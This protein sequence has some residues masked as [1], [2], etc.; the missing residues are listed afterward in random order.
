MPY[1]EQEEKQITYIHEQ[2]EKC[3][4]GKIPPLLETEKVKLTEL[5]AV[6]GGTEKIQ[7][8]NPAKPENFVA[9]EVKKSLNQGPLREYAE[10]IIIKICAY[11]KERFQRRVGAG[12]LDDP[13]NLLLEEFKSW[14][15]HTLSAFS[16]QIDLQQQVQTRM[17]YLKMVEKSELFPAG[18]MGDLHLGSTLLEVIDVLQAA[19]ITIKATLDSA[20]AE[21][22]LNQLVCSSKHLLQHLT[23]YLYFIFREEISDDFTFANIRHPHDKDKSMRTILKTKTGQFLQSL[24]QSPPFLRLFLDEKIATLA[25][26]STG[27]LI[28]LPV[29]QT[30]EANPFLNKDLLPTED[31]LKDYGIYP[32]FLAQPHVIES[33]IELHA[34]LLEFGHFTL[35]CEDL[36]GLAKWGGDILIYG[37]ANQKVASFLQN[38]F[39]LIAAIFSRLDAIQKFSQTTYKAKKQ[40]V[41]RDDWLKNYN[42][43]ESIYGEIENDK[44]TCDHYATVILTKARQG[45]NE[46]HRKRIQDQIIHVLGEIDRFSERMDHFMPNTSLMGAQLLLIQQDKMLFIEQN[47]YTPMHQKPSIQENT[48]SIQENTMEQK[49]AKNTKE[50]K[51]KEQKREVPVQRTQSFSQ[52]RKEQF[53]G[54]N[55]KSSKHTNSVWNSSRPIDNSKNRESSKLLDDPSSSEDDFSDEK[56]DK[57]FN[58]DYQLTFKECKIPFYIES[59]ITSFDDPIYAKNIA[60]LWEDHFPQQKQMGGK[61]KRLP[62]IAENKKEN[63]SP[64]N[65]LDEFE[66]G[67]HLKTAGPLARKVTDVIEQFEKNDLDYQ[68][69]DGFIAKVCDED[70]LWEACHNEL[71]YLKYL[72][73]KSAKSDDDQ[74][75]SET[76][77]RDLKDF[78]EQLKDE[79]P[80][81]KGWNRF[82]DYRNLKNQLIDV[83]ESIKRHDLK[84]R[85]I[86][87]N[88][89]HYIRECKRLE[90]ELKNQEKRMDDQENKYQ[91]DI[92]RLQSIINRKDAL[93]NNQDKE[94]KK[95]E[96]EIEKQTNVI[97]DQENTLKNHESTISNQN[98]TNNAYD[99][100]FKKQTSINKLL[101]S[102]LISQGNLPE[103]QQQVI[104]NLLEEESSAGNVSTKTL[105]MKFF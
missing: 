2:Y 47:P 42:Q 5:L 41:C 39:S 3:G 54:L 64:S 100:Q 92:L 60:A 73:V 104:K 55:K 69:P 12:S 95:R 7:G 27:E 61:G 57:L 29:S 58:M 36:K 56:I 79:S 15:V 89:A 74:W 93:I 33:F 97:I 102:M 67:L 44:R 14:T 13:I 87:H 105:N 99:T 65:F 37:L 9:S 82:S 23:Q 6:V 31:N 80:I 59:N 70:I 30:F 16:C 52:Q 63:T 18:R 78:I 32:V 26:S 25:T 11:Q 86:P 84:P 101:A 68:K 17:N 50:E 43:A 38:Y 103:D 20:S 98:K 34:L 19:K 21:V 94:L 45:I 88:Q 76:D 90:N 91:E 53:S 48:L 49:N 77:E 24:V 62:T 85:K 81:G 71:F 96:E 83:Y 72:C 46:Y 1:S 51:K 35:I 40:A 8:K 22:E 66:K 28:V 10:N 4:L 75:S